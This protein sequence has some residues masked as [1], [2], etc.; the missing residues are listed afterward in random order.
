MTTGVG[1]GLIE[2][3]ITFLAVILASIASYGGYLVSFKSDNSHAGS[4]CASMVVF[5][6]IMGTF[7]Y[8]SRNWKM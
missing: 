8:L 7:G 3:T 4:V 5:N 1:A 2:V 6:V